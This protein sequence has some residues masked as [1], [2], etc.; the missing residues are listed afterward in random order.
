[1]FVFGWRGVVTRV[2]RRDPGENGRFWEE[3]GL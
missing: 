2:T 3:N 1:M